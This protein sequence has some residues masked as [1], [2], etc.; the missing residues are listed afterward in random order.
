MLVLPVVAALCAVAPS[1]PAPSSSM[2]PLP[3]PSAASTTAP[4]PANA[5][6]DSPF[7]KVES[8]EIDY[9]RNGDF[10]IP[11]KVVFSRPGSDGTAERASG[12]EKR[13]TV[14]LFGNVVVHDN[15]NAPEAGTDEYSKGGPSTLTCD[16]LD[17][18]AK[19]KIYTAIGHVHFVQGAR[20]ATAQRGVLNRST[21]TL[22]LVGDV[23]TKDGE[24]TL[25]ANDVSYNT[26]TKDFEGNGKPIIIKQPGP[27]PEPGSAS[28]TPKPKTRKLPF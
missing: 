11:H 24:S 16:Q 5:A 10:D 21:G 9:K 22:Q 4:R 13:G 20:V 27:P 7:Y 12:N 23:K 26:N 25:T 14:S 1:A 8:D 19:M 6:L 15:G 17:I 18:D 28:P 2:T 3:A